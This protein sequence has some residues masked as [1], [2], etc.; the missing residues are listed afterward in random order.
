MRNSYLAAGRLMTHPAFSMRQGALVC[1]VCQQAHTRVRA[2]DVDFLAHDPDPELAF[3]YLSARTYER[4]AGKR[5]WPD[6]QR[7]LDR[8]EQP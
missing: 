6:P 3:Q 5:D 4:E 8:K 1:P 2:Y 7:M